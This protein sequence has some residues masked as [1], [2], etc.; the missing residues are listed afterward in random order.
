MMID[1]YASSEMLRLHTLVETEE[2]QQVIAAP[3]VG[4][5]SN[6]PRPGDI[7]VGGSFIGRLKTLNSS[8]HL[9]LPDNVSGQV[10]VNEAKDFVYAVQYGQELF[11]LRTGV[12]L[13]SD[14]VEG[15]TAASHSGDNE[16]PQES[17]FLVKAF[18]NG[19]FYAQPS[20]D[21]PPFVSVGQ[22]IEK[23][24]ALGLIEVMKTF[25]HIVFQGTGDSNTGTIKK[26]YVKDSQEVKQ[27]QPL[28]LI[29]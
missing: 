21:S 25:N 22:E 29:D 15:G 26:I 8:Y 17:G 4:Y 24:K 14:Q 19:I 18:T 12:D 7:L 13:L 20:P 10:M 2:S 9:F 6:S 1:Y 5:F 16:D 23:G 3:T 11:R 27:D 28:F